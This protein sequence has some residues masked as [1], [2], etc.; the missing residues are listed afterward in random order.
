MKNSLRFYAQPWK[1]V[2]MQKA[3]Y[4]KTER[5]SEIC[6]DIG[7]VIFAAVFID[8]F[9]SKSYSVISISLGLLFSVT[10]WYM[11]LLALRKRR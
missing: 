11:S 7:Q 3:I 2:C 9:L 6:R 5:M 10:F 8:P 4:I 1:N